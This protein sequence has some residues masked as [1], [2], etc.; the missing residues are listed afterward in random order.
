MSPAGTGD[1]AGTV[2]GAS[3]VRV[4][5]AAGRP[6]CADGGPGAGTPTRR[7]RPSGRGVVQRGVRRRFGDGSAGGGKRGDAARRRRVAERVADRLDGRPA[8]GC[9]RRSG[10]LRSGAARRARRR[11]RRRRRARRRSSCPGGTISRS[12]ATNSS[13]T[14]TSTSLAVTAPA[15]APIPPATSMPT[16]PPSSRPNSPLH[17]AG[18][19][20]RRARLEVLRL[21]DV[22]L[23]VGRS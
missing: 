19:D 4:D 12:W 11:R 18:A 21:A 6:S 13:V 8:A 7:L 22:G 16:G 3:G 5:R 23:A 14:P 9:R 10:R 15:P 20:R 17:S 2:D 1:P